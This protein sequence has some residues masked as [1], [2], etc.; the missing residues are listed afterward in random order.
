M[1]TTGITIAPLLPRISYLD[2][3]LPPLLILL[4]LL[5]HTIYNEP[6]P[7][8][9]IH[10]HLFHARTAHARFLPIQAKH[11]F[12]YPVLFY[13]V[14]LD[15][16]QDHTT[17]LGRLFGYRSSKKAAWR[18]TALS[19]T[20]YLDADSPREGGKS[21]KAK[22]VDYLEK[23]GVGREFAKRVYTVTMPAYLGFE[24]INPLTVH[25]CYSEQEEER[26]RLEIVVLEV[27]NTFGERHIYLLRTETG[28]DEVVVAG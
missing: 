7:S 13:G 10:A 16:L 1:N 28:Q 15:R 14:D 24:G 25:Y 19:P 12:S 2:I 4:S 11:I 27:H 23:K 21:I 17:D 26:R 6:P 3:L 22:L 8:N 18:I 20:A 9:P 5:L